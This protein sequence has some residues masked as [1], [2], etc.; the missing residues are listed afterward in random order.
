MVQTIK[1]VRSMEDIPTNELNN[2]LSHFTM[3]IRKH[4][5]AEC[6]VYC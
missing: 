1:E 5:G 2:L 4:N 6:I 3:K